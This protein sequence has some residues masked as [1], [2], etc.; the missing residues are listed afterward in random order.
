MAERMIPLTEAQ[1]H[2]LAR[3]PTQPVVE[4]PLGEAFGL[5]VA[6]DVASRFRGAGRGC[7][8]IVPESDR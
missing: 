7:G 4:V 6:V 5:V 8:D 3:M 1:D 2:V